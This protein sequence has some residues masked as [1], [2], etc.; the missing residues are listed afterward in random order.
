MKKVFSLLL[1]FSLLFTL[2]CKDDDKKQVDIDKNALILGSW[3]LVETN[4]PA[5]VPPS[6]IYTF[7]ENGIFNASLT[8]RVVSRAGSITEGT[9]RFVDPQQIQLE[10]VTIAPEILTIDILNESTL[11]LRKDN[12]SMV[13]TRQ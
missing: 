10:I 12:I 13:M 11:K 7:S 4:D 5:G 2:A 8:T 3:R 1:T 6:L 9:W